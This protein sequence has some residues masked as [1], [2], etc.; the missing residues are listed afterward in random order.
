MCSAGTQQNS[1]I[2]CCA[3]AGSDSSNAVNSVQC[4]EYGRSDNVFILE[5]A[6]WINFKLIMQAY[7]YFILLLAKKGSPCHVGALNDN[8]GSTIK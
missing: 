1:D 5:T 4:A 3:L 2:L 6:Q 8:V 7:S